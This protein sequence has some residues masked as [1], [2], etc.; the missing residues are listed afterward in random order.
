LIEEVHRILRPSGIARFAVQ[1]M[2]SL[3]RRYLNKDT[4]FFFQK[5]QDGKDRF[6]GPTLGD[7]FASWFYGFAIKGNPCRYFYDFDSLA[8]LF[9]SAGFSVVER[10][11]FLE[12]RLDHIELIDNREDQMFF[13]EAIK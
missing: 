8:Y 7:K 1:D 13:L 4:E 11:A 12:S 10:K 9:W 2:E 3:A 5:S 6:P